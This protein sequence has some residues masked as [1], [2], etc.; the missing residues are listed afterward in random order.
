MYVC[1]AAVFVLF[2]SVTIQP[3]NTGKVHENKEKDAYIPLQT[4]NKP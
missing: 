2:L 3:W 1:S 4:Y